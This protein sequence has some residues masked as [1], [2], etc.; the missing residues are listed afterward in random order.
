MDNL[1]KVEKLRE[2]SGISYEEA[3]AALESCNYDLLDAVIKLEQQGKIPKPDVEVFTTKNDSEEQSGDFE[4]AQRN[5][6]ESCKKG[7][8]IG[9]VLNSFFKWCGEIL[10]K[11]MDTMFC[12]SNKR[13]E[14]IMRI[15]L[16]LLIIAC[17]LAFWLVIFMLCI[18]LFSGCRFQFEDV[19]EIRVDVNE[20]CDKASEA[21]D[22]VKQSFSNEQ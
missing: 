8:S 14:S 5:Y 12:V 19:G 4:R 7:N 9:D 15:P 13:G 21:C 17:L 2:K 10:Q 18:G 1:E 3:K 20:M 11:S 22:T 6:K 16:L